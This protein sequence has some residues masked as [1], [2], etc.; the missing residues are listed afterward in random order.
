MAPGVQVMLWGAAVI[1]TVALN[2]RH[3]GDPDAFGLSVMLLMIWVMGR[4]MWAILAPPQSQAMYPLF[5]FLGGATAFLAFQTRIAWWK[6]ALS[7]FFLAQL[8][9][10]SLFWA[11]KAL[12]LPVTINQYEYTAINNA[13]FAMQLSVVGWRGVR[14]GVLASRIRAWVRHRPGL[15]HHSRG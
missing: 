1:A 4:I 2:Y 10:H 11:S 13:I 12:Q 7:L 9:L 14:D 15:G 6:L 3:K 5:D 8:C